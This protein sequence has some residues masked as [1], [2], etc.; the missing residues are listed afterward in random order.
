MASLYEYY[1]AGDNTE[2]VLYENGWRAQTFTVGASGHTCYSVK[3][4]CYKDNPADVGDAI[5]GIRA[6]DGSGFPTGEDLTS[7]IIAMSSIP[8]S[9]GWVE[10]VMTTEIT[11][12][13]LTKYA[14]VMRRPASYGNSW[15][16][17]Y[18]STVPTYALGNY[19]T[20]ITSGG[21]WTDVLTSD[22]MFEVWGSEETVGGTKTYGDG[23]VWFVYA[24]KQ[25]NRFPNFNPKLFKYPVFGK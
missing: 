13:A 21:S 10:F 1:N 7:K 12:T 2:T 4:K 25:K 9:A 6:T 3:L 5:V 24:N 11:L 18:D 17:R 23:L 14:I 15:I 20:S 16:I 22:F 19:E 8:D